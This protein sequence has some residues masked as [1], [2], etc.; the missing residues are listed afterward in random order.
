MKDHVERHCEPLTQG[1]G[2]GVP[3]EAINVLLN[4]NNTTAICIE[5]SRVF[6]I[7][8]PY[9]LRANLSRLICLKNQK[10]PQV[11]KQPWAQKFAFKHY[12]KQH[13]AIAPQYIRRNVKANLIAVFIVILSW[14]SLCVK[15]SWF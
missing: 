11:D 5:R 9:S 12:Y 4:V 8:K 13:T 15:H 14:F 1:E 3:G 7:S 6:F 2:L 10:F